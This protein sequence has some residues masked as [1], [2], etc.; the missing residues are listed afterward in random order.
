MVEEQGAGEGDEEEG[1]EEVPRT[2]DGCWANAELEMNT[3]CFFVC[4]NSSVLN[5]KGQYALFN[6]LNL[7]AD[8][9][10]I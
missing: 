2:S 1:A 8:A 5:I 3:R 7:P 10:I 4:L 9:Y 6:L